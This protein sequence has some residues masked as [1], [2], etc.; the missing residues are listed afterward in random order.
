MNVHVYGT[1]S[2]NLSQVLLFCVQDNQD[3]SKLQIEMTNLTQG[4]RVE[5]D[6]NVN[7]QLQSELAS[8]REEMAELRAKQYLDVNDLKNRLTDTRLELSEARTEA[9]LKGELAGLHAKQN[10]MTKQLIDTQ[11][12]LSESRTEV[13]EMRAA[14]FRL[15]AHVESKHVAGADGGT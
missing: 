3:T 2:S 10:E 8:L 14:H 7:A 5:L 12:E 15:E 4:K 6:V 11:L 13:I 1:E 9:V